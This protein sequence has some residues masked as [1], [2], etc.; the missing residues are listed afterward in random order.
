M[1]GNNNMRK[2]KKKSGLNLA[3]FTLLETMIAVAIFAVVVLLASRIFQS[4]LSSQ[5]TN[6]VDQ[7]VQENV[8]YFLESLT[9]ET[10]TALRNTSGADLCGVGANHIFA[11]NATSSQLF[12]ENASG[13]CVEYF[14]S[15][16]SSGL[17]RLAVSR[18][19][20]AYYLTS[21]RVAVKSLKFVVDDVTTST[22][23]LLTV[24]VQVQSENNQNIPA[25][26][27]QTSISPI[28]Y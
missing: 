4:V 27:I 28:T 11:V 6:A 3:A 7:D 22:Q 25:Y 1:I 15:I 10:R 18:D 5:K 8:K 2:N 23:P 24:N 17:T 13:Q 21:N 14:S 9:R 20:A 19:A 12:F 26:N 16:D